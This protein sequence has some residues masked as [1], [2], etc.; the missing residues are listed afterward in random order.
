MVNFVDHICPCLEEGGE[1]QFAKQKNIVWGS[2]N[3]IKFEKMREIVKSVCIHGL[4]PELPSFSSASSNFCSGSFGDGTRNII[5]RP[6]SRLLIDSR[7]RLIGISDC[8][9]LTILYDYWCYHYSGGSSLVQVK[10]EDT[11][12]ILW[13]QSKSFGC[14]PYSSGSGYH[15]YNIPLIFTLHKRI[16]IYF[17]SSKYG[18]YSYNK[19]WEFENFNPTQP[20]NLQYSI[21]EDDNWQLYQSKFPYCA[22]PSCSINLYLGDNL[23]YRGKYTTDG[24]LN[25]SWKPAAWDHSPYIIVSIPKSYCWSKH[26]ISYLQFYLSGNLPLSMDLYGRTYTLDWES[27][28]TKNSF[29]KGWNSIHIPEKTSTAYCGTVGYY[30]YIKL[31]FTGNVQIN[32]MRYYYEVKP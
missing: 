17:T 18:N 27:I 21:W 19:L 10:D 14:G 26:I 22:Y 9:Q 4:G 31:A 28:T 32:E 13:S 6:K 3:A 16:G 15:I 30:Y 7:D 2:G 1:S 24:D 11:S 12:K 20:D 8:G 23:S 25:T 5:F 29:K